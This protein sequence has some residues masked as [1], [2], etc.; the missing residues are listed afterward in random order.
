M[1][2]Y[3]STLVIGVL[4]FALVSLTAVSANAQTTLKSYALSLPSYGGPAYTAAETKFISNS[5]GYLS[6]ERINSPW[7]ASAKEC[8]NK[9]QACG[10][11]VNNIYYVGG[12]KL[13]PN[14]IVIGSSVNMQQWLSTWNVS[15]ISAYGYF[16]GE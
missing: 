4:A 1:R 5:A 9:V 3:K 8:M 14:S 2:I 15:A 11:T 16:A 7:D 13:L 12:D 10:T 6:P